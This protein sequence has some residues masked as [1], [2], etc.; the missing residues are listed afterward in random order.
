MHISYVYISK[1]DTIKNAK[2]YVIINTCITI[3]A[4]QDSKMQQL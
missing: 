2:Y 4:C 3:L 1:I